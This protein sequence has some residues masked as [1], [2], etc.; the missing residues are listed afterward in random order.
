MAGIE[1]SGVARA[2][3]DVHAVR[4][5]TFTVEPGHVA[6][7]IGPNGAGKTTLLLMLASLLRPDA[8]TIRVAGF[9]PV[10]DPAEVRAR[11]GWM[12]DLLG[13]WASL[14]VREALVTSARLYGRSTDAARARAD[15]LIGLVDLDELADRPTRVL[16]RGQKQ[17]LSLA[18]ALVH[19]PEVLLLD[20]PASGLDPVA[21][22][23]LRALVRRLAS[24]GRT[25]LVS[26]HV[27]AELEEMADQAVYLSGGVTAA[28]D[29]I[30]RAARTARDWRV[31]SLDP[32][33]LRTALDAAGWGEVA[34][35]DNLGAIVPL[36]SEEDAAQL[37]AH[38]IGSG[39]PI[40]SFAPAVGDLEHV[41]L[42]LSRNGEE[43]A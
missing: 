9:D 37:I 32:E 14:T 19:D 16:S 39:V 4:N 29:E 20:E 15:D 18:R 1:V 6:G 31:R 41:F 27:L 12:P 34:R 28:A 13:S 7:L 35:I 5:A 22:A 36:A 24:E 8:G 42:D 33:R 2:F 23:G 25:V 38:L 43:D 17:R 21:R 3:G 10:T 40:S 26:S 30:E 11:M